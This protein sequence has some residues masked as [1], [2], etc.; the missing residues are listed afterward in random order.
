ML[1]CFYLWDASVCVSPH[2][3]TQAVDLGGSHT[4]QLHALFIVGD[5]ASQVGHLNEE[6]KEK[7]T[8]WL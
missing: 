2:L 7:G 1:V 4:N 8:Q 6:S 5:G 3:W